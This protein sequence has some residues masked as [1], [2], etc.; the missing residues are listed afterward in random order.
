M[1]DFITI[2]SV[3][4]D[5]FFRTG[6]FEARSHEDSPTGAEQCFPLGSKL[7]IKEMIFATGGGGANAAVTFARQGWKTAALGVIGQDFNGRDVLEELSREGVE[8]KYFQ[9]HDD[10]HTAYSVI[11]VNSSG[12]RTI[13][14]YKGEGQHFKVTSIPFDQLETKW[15]FLD[16][17][18]GNLDLLKTVMAHTAHHDIKVAMNP[19]GQELACGLEKLSPVLRS[20][21]VFITNREEGGQLL[22]SSAMDHRQV[23]ERLKEV[24]GGITVVTD[25]P[26]G[27]MVK[28]VIGKV[29]GAGIPNSPVVERTGAGDAWSSGFVSEYSREGNIEKA[30]QFATANASSVVTKFGAKA[31]ILAKG[32]WG[33]WPL[34]EVKS[35]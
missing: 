8:T 25:G 31:G 12:E 30:I 7:E 6:D 27:A 22:G 19:G 4:R 32:D 3:T 35:I 20:L 14:S 16:S 29:Y 15:F 9:E 2:G 13:L 23:L 18:G 17:M 1:Y 11:L 21:E 33:H 34:V 24:V 26:R 5:V 10:D 28:D